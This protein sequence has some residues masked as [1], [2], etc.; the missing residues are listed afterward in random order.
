[1]STRLRS[2]LVVAATI[3][4]EL[5]FWDGEVRLAGGGAMPLWLPI[6][7]TVAVHSSLWWRRSHPLAVLGVQLAF[8]MVSLGVPLWQPV[9]G[10]LVAVFSVA[11]TT[12]ARPARWGWLAAVPLLTHTLALARTGDI[13][14]FSLAQAFC[15]NLAAGAAA[16]FAGRLK[17]R[18]A[19]QLRA[20]QADQ[21]R[22]RDEDAQRERLALARELHDGVANTITTVLI[23][24][25]A[26]KASDRGP[27]ALPGIESSARRAMEEI[28]QLLRLMPREADAADGPQLADLPALL[29]LAEQAGLRLD[30]AE[31]GARLELGP[32]AQTAVYRAVQEGVT[33]AL[34]YAPTGTHCSVTLT[35]TATELSVAVVDEPPRAS[36]PA[37]TL[38]DPALPATGG[39]GLAGLQERLR[40]LGGGLESGAVRDGF[41]LAARVPVGVR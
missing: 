7:V 35:W 24:A 16:W 22:L 27:A 8:A 2:L 25:A 31:T 21:Q 6:A 37:P 41:R 20:W 36:G 13:D 23:Q 26:A 38:P 17:H 1:M 32:A 39:R 29:A 14:A 10:L 40:G 15:L 34:K 12:S 33:N 3:A 11:A 30:F 9:A 28:Q 18:R 5:T 4:V 19:E